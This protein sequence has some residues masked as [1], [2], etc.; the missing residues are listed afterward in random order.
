MTKFSE[1]LAKYA[2]WDCNFGTDKTITHAYG[3][4]YDSLFEPM[5]KSARR[6]LEIGVYS[7]AS[8]LSFAEFFE[9]ATVDGIDISKESIKFG[10]DNPRITY[11]LLDGTKQSTRDQLTDKYDVILEDAS[12]EPY[13]QIE[14]FRLFASSLAPGGVFIMEDVN[15]L[16][17]ELL[18]KEMGEIARSHGLEVEWH[19]LRSIKGRFDDIVGVFRK[20]MSKPIL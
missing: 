8:V 6:V 11:H 13:D 18:V 4:L 5:Q 16:H 2:H 20:K 10:L 19:D 3:D 15:G 14:T 9:G 7:G 1:V 12:H 17:Y